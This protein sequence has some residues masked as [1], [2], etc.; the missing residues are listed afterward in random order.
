MVEHDLESPGIEQGLT[1][2]VLKFNNFIVH[3][4]MEMHSNK[5]TNISQHA[6]FL[7]SVIS[8]IILFFWIKYILKTNLLPWTFNIHILYRQSCP[9]VKIE[10]PHELYIISLFWWYMVHSD[11]HHAN[12]GNIV[13]PSLLGLLITVLINVYYY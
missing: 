5:G 8:H 1:T 11:K 7:L 10:F 2:N 3:N 6:I 9:V 4:Y 12:I 13:P